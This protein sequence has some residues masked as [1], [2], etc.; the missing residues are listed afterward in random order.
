MQ[1]VVAYALQASYK[2]L[3]ELFVKA[4]LQS[5]QIFQPTSDRIDQ[6]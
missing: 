5:I 6:T 4:K 3:V 2:E 1:Y